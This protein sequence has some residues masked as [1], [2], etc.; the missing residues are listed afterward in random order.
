ISITI[1][2]NLKNTNPPPPPPAKRRRRRPMTDGT[3]ST[4]NAMIENMLRGGGGGGLPPLKDV[5]WMKPPSNNFTVWRDHMNDSFNTTIPQGQAQQMGL[6]PLPRVEAPPPPPLALT[7]PPGLSAATDTPLTMREFAMIMMQQGQNGGNA[8]RQ[9]SQNLHEDPYND[10]ESM[11][12]RYANLRPSSR[13]EEIDGNVLREA[14]ATHEQINNYQEQILQGRGINTTNEQKLATAGMDPEIIQTVKKITEMKKAGTYQGSR[15]IKPYGDHIN[16]PNFIA[17]YNAGRALWFSQ[18]PADRKTAKDRKKKYTFLGEDEDPWAG[19]DTGIEPAEDI[20]Y[21]VPDQSP[22]FSNID[23]EFVTVRKKKEEAQ[24]SKLLV[25]AGLRKDPE[26]EAKVNADIKQIIQES[27]SAKLLTRAMQTRNARKEAKKLQEEKEN[28]RLD[29]LNQQIM[30]EREQK[31]QAKE[32]AG[33]VI[34][35]AMTTY[36]ANKEKKALVQKMK[37][38]LQAEIAT[39]Q[40]E[41]KAGS[42]E[43]KEPSAKSKG[44]NKAL[45]SIKDFWL[46]DT[47]QEEQRQAR[48]DKRQALRDAQK[49]TEDNL[50][51]KIKALT[52]KRKQLEALGK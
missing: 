35:K 1:E 43:Q 10:N 22:D 51:A 21:D 48:K 39:L 27:E 6:L 40:E 33:K 20:F 41:L 50:A 25:A 45:E 42:R 2:N 18:Q 12:D 49:E 32:Q 4:S 23:S 26:I 47:T 29:Q 38:A 14:G 24:L 13:I 19:S 34:T 44:I 52:D 7:A 5:S 11:D 36:K 31:K 17:S 15:N 8:M 28:K 46:A 37:E 9:G 3:N 30:T 16:D